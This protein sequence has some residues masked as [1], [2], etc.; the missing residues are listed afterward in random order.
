MLAISR[1]TESG[2]G[3]EAASLITLIGVTSLIMLNALIVGVNG[4]GQV[5]LG[6][7]PNAFWMR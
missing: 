7:Q 1:V 2:S 5:L 3:I 6:W 4:C